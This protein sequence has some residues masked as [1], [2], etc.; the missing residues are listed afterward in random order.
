MPVVALLYSRPR[1][2]AF[3]LCSRYGK[4]TTCA[5]LNVSN[6]H[7]CQIVLTHN[8]NDAESLR[9]LRRLRL[10]DS[11]TGRHWDVAELEIS[12]LR[13]NVEL[14]M[15]ELRE[16]LAELGMMGLAELQP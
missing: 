10:S 7:P 15:L 8:N 4:R 9:L 11:P 1:E 2:H 6:P 3:T 16:D 14:G 5:A 12:G 13:G